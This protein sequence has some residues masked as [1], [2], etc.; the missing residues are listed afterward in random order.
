M[1]HIEEADE[2]E[3]DREFGLREAFLE[4]VDNVMPTWQEHQQSQL[5]LRQIG[6]GSFGTIHEIPGTPWALKHESHIEDPSKPGAWSLWSE[7]VVHAKLAQ[8]YEEVFFLH[9]IVLLPR[10]HSFIDQTSGWWTTGN[11]NR[12]PEAS[13]PKRRA[14]EAIQAEKIQPLSLSIRH[15]LIDLYCKPETK[16]AARATPSNQDCLARIYLGKKS[17]MATAGRRNPFF[18]LRNFK[19][20]LDQMEQIG[21]DTAYYTRGIAETLAIIHFVAQLDGRDIEFVFGSA[22]TSTLAPRKPNAKDLVGL[23]DAGA[24]HGSPDD[25]RAVRMWVLDFNQCR[26]ITMDEQG[27]VQAADAF[28]MNDP[29]FPRP[30]QPL[31]EI[32]AGSYLDFTSRIIAIGKTHSGATELAQRFLEEV[33]RSRRVGDKVVQTNG[34]DGMEINGHGTDS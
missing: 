18:S 20:H 30:D 10:L 13:K 27:M 31:W 6:A 23:T 14:L 26:S 8:A 2:I 19:L 3:V 5:P 32:F 1:V 25:R 7:Y 29:Y 21:L 16:D 22:A 12:F 15:M 4:D 34:V 33:K 17:V 28:W 24:L 11:F 9:P